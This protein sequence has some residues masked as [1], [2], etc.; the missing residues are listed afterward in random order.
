MIKV[1]IDFHKHGSTQKTKTLAEL[2]IYN[3]GEGTW[4]DGDYK[5]CLLSPD[6]L[7]FRECHVAH[8][9]RLRKKV[10]HLLYEVLKRMIEGEEDVDTGQKRLAG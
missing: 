9:P 8:F 4:E 7:T 5:A 1:T 3:T 10:W 6:G 2:I